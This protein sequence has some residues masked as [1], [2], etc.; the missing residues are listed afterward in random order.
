LVT[1]LVISLSLGGYLT[2]ASAQQEGGKPF[3]ALWDAVK[4]LQQ[5]IDAIVLLPGP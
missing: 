3:Q 4:N 1:V 5:Q 2:M